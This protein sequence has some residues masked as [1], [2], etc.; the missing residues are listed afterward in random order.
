M[1]GGRCL[2]FLMG[3][4]AAPLLQSTAAQSSPQPPYQAP[5]REDDAT[6]LVVMIE[7]AAVAGILSRRQGRK[8]RTT[9][10]EK[11]AHQK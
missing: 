9:K 8:P 4:H 2:F 6:V 5:T 11:G 7:A 10:F 3:L 1:L